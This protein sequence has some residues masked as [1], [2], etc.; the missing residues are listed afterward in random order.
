M[1]VTAVRKET[2]ESCTVTYD[3]GEGMSD[4]VSKFGEEAVFSHARRSFIVA[5]Q[6]YVR[7]LMAQNKSQSEIQAAVDEWKP[8]NRR[9]GKSVQDRLFD[10]LSKLPPAERARVIKEA[11][12]QEKAAAT[13]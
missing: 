6:S 10:L 11:R 9:Q 1:E 3:F 4:L 7:G 12:A 8:G 2:G 5:L 13:G